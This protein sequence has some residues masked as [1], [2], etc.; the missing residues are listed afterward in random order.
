MR[1]PVCVCVPVCACASVCVCVCVCVCVSL[2]PRVLITS[3]MMWTLY[4][5][6]N[7]FYSFYMAVI[8]SIVNGH[9]LTIELH[10]RNV[11]NKS[12]LVLC[13]L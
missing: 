13:K 7:K 10:P 3:G 1:V 2:P 8:V 9:C 5:W 12:K 11:P 4:D 6:L